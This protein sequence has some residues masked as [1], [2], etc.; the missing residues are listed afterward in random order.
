M[1]GGIKM[2]NRPIGFMDSG[3]GGLTVVKVAK[4]L[5]PN[6]EI[7]F[8]GDEARMPYGPRPTA[9]VVEYSQ[10]M[11]AFLMQK[12]IKALVIACN[13]AT[14][15]ALDVLKRTLP[16]PVLGVI[17]PGATAAARQT[18][19][20]R[21]GVIATSGTITSKAY[22]TTLTEVAPEIKAFPLACQDFVAIAERN[23]MD[24]PQTMATV[25]KQLAPLKA[26]QI[27]TL[28]LGCT[29]FPLL[30]KSIQAAVGDQVQLVD[31]GVETVSQLAQLLKERDEEHALDVATNDQYFSTGGIREFT[32]IA[33]NLLQQ[34]VKVNQVKID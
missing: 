21:V 30:A 27:D 6:E 24:T 31:P 5:L 19:N 1:S 34:S 4:E 25:Q 10:Q 2:D 28:I 14:N 29:H 9:E 20:Q 13:T 33:E 8:I 11:A 22:P 15:A 32:L 26:E 3:V 17:L 7:I 18:K 23:E 16:I 12:K